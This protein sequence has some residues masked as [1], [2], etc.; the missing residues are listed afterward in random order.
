MIILKIRVPVFIAA[1]DLVF[2]FALPVTQLP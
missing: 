1:G 2:P